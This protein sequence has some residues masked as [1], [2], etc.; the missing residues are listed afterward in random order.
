MPPPV[1]LLTR[2]FFEQRSAGAHVTA[3]DRVPVGGPSLA[4]LAAAA[5][6]PFS[7]LSLSSRGPRTLG[8]KPLDGEGGPP[9]RDPSSR[10]EKWA[11]PK[12]ARAGA[13]PAD[14]GPAASGSYRPA[15]S[16]RQ[17][18]HGSIA[19][20]ALA[21][22]RSRGTQQ[23]VRRGGVGGGGGG[24]GRRVGDCWPGNAEL[25][26]VD[27][28]GG[29]RRGGGGGGGIVHCTALRTARGAAPDEGC[30]EGEKTGMG[31]GRIVEGGRERAREIQV[32]RYRGRGRGRER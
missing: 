27:A 31:M 10:T 2:P 21:R 3:C 32:E 4:P 17:A 24:G 6:P 7:S 19:A 26:P 1:S 29:G 12:Q 22:H 5:S 23:I 9:L 28:G 13:R 16:V 11:T 30:G 15:P 14:P 8:S 20:A 18:A 25:G